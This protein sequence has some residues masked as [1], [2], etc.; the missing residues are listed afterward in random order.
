MVYD[1]FSSI[2]MVFNSFSQN[3]FINPT[4]GTGILRKL[5]TTTFKIPIWV[6]I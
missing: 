6:I 3:S 5:N 4:E 1:S 2:A